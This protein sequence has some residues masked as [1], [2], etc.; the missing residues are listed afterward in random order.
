VKKLAFTKMQGTGNDFVVLDGIRR[1]VRVT[2]ALARALC[3]RRFGAGADQVLVLEKSRVA[4]FRMRIYNADGSQVEMCGNGIRCLALFAREKGHTRATSF[5]V[6]TLGGVKRPTVLGRR[7][8]VDMGEPVL[9]AGRVPT[10]AVGRVLERPLASVLGAAA[11]AV[12]GPAGRTL[13]GTAVSMGNPHCVIFVDDVAAVPL[14]VWGPAIERDAFFPRRANVEF[15]AVENPDR[16]AVRVWERGSGAT[17]ACGTGACAVGVAGVLT[18]R[19]HRRVSL[20][21]PG[22]SLDVEWAPDNHVY[23]NGP[24]AFVYDGVWR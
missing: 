11:R 21:L 9:D 16:A 10:R 7:V 15:V 4:D 3:D 23:L 13:R 8:R 24:A 14:D 12:L 6:E 2:P 18:G 5:T 22:G 17:L 19:L 1:P 20:S